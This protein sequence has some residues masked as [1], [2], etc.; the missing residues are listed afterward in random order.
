ALKINP[1]DAEIH[2][3]L[4]VLLYE[5]PRYKEI[6]R[7][8]KLTFYGEA[9][10]EFR[11]A[12]K[13]DPEFAE[14]HN[15][16][17]VLLS[18]L[19][20]YEEAEKEFRKAIGIDPSYDEAYY[21]LGDLFFDLERFSEAKKEFKKAVEIDPENADYYNDLG[22]TYRELKKKED[23]KRNYLIAIDKNPEFSEPYY[24]LAIILTEE[25]LNEDAIY[26]CEK[27]LRL[28]EENE[29]KSKI[30]NSIGYCYIKLKNEDI[31]KKYFE[32][33]LT[34]DKHNAKAF[35]NLKEVEKARRFIFRKEKPQHKKFEISLCLLLI[36]FTILRIIE[37]DNFLILRRFP[38]KG[39][40]S[41]EFTVIFIL[42]ISFIVIVELF[43]EIIELKFKVGASGIEFD[44]KKDIKLAKSLSETKS[45]KSRYK[46]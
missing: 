15:N 46:R 27:A 24:N 45:S 33:S 21:N 35:E 17:G 9:E 20:R 3:N 4:G 39:I 12:I 41:N 28:E 13:I 8:E 44:F 25:E 16:F 1:K 29:E 7:K 36:F 19:E 6:K 26:Y 34:Q 14:P 23:A 5:L 18:E 30:L 37:F 38:I 40:T 10:K 22:N 42:L 31:A 43:P 11:E 2:N 32:D